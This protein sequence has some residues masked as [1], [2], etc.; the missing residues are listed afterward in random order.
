MA[1]FLS[2]KQQQ[3]YNLYYDNSEALRVECSP[4]IKPPVFFSRYFSDECSGKIESRV[5]NITNHFNRT[6]SKL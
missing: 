2:Q 1:D 4:Q 6:V 5:I 3:Q